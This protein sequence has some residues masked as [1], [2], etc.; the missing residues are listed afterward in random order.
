MTDSDSEVP[1]NPFTRFSDVM[2]LEKIAPLKIAV[3][4]A[5][6]I[7]VPACL[8]LAKMGVHSLHVWDIDSVAPENVGPQM[9]GSR[10]IGRPKTLALG[11]FLNDQAKWCEVTVHNKLFVKQEG[12]FED[13][14]VVVSAVDTLEV[15]KEIWESIDP[16]CRKLLVD[17]RM[18]AEVLTVFSVIP[19]EDRSWY[20]NT[21]EGEAMEF[22]CTAKATFHNGLVA[23][24]MVA[25]AV[26][27]HIMNERIYAETTFDMRYLQ[28]FT[29]TPDQKVA[30][31]NKAE[32]AAE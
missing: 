13:F 18:G 11:Q 15:R 8:C 28:L 23:G 6:G 14:D 1:S 32:E 20:P 30:T 31:M 24:A 16:D 27:A 25:Q 12:V 29:A 17:P 21:L 22:A 2:P 5:G 7:G 26:K 4:G 10:V 3:I 9:Y 19:Q